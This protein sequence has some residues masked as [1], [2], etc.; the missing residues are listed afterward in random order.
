MASIDDLEAQ[1]KVAPV[2]AD[3]ELE[4]IKNRFISKFGFQ[5]NRGEMTRHL[6]ELLDFVKAHR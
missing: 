1:R 3:K 4:A 2:E 5:Y 6:D